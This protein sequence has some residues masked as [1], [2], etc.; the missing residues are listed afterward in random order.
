MFDVRFECETARL[1]NLKDMY[2]VILT[3]NVQSYEL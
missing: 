3:L 1:L 2:W